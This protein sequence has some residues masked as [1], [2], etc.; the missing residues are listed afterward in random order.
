M[1]IRHEP[2]SENGQDFTCTQ[3]GAPLDE[4]EIGRANDRSQL[5]CAEVKR[6]HD[7]RE[8]PEPTLADLLLEARYQGEK[9]GAGPWEV[10]R[11]PKLVEAVQSMCHSNALMG[12]KL[13]GFALPQASDGARSHLRNVIEELQETL[14]EK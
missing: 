5:S 7:W 13:A 10:E 11:L 4:D 14:K 6:A 1:N 9:E 12:L 3:C 2:A 8:N